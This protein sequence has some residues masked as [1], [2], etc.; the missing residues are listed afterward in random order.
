MTSVAAPETA[1]VGLERAAYISL[2]AFAA[3][4][5]LSIAVAGIFLTLT[6][7]LWLALVVR[8]RERVQVPPMFWPLAAYGAATLVATLFSIDP[9]TSLI[10]DKQLLLFLIIPIAYRLLPGR[11]S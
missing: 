6:G 10:D 7:V 8:G 9:W 4:T 5:Q 1:P 2:L 11:R 3:V